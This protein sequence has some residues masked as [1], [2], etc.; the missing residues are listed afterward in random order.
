MFKNRLGENGIIVRNKAI[1]GAQ[2]YNQEE[3][4]EFDETFA[5]VAR[6]G[7]IRLLLS[8]VC[9]LNFQLYQTDIVI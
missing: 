8:Y 4:I 6:L 5:P 2:R 9:S 1:L 7:V 3:G